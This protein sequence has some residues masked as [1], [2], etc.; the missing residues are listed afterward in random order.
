LKPAQG[1]SS[2][3]PVSK[4]PN[5]KRADGVAQGVGCEFKPWYRKKKKSKVISTSTSS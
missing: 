4:I 3:D 1:N 5:M 2:Q